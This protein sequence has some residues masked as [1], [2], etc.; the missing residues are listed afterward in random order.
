M[1]KLEILL[2]LLFSIVISLFKNHSALAMENLALR[3]QLSIYH[4]SKKRPRIRLR[5]R[6]FWIVVP[7]NPFAENRPAFSFR[8]IVLKEISMINV[9]ALSMIARRKSWLY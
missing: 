3:Q 8:D 1:E 9:K 2:N 6:L 7:E 4:H 5:D